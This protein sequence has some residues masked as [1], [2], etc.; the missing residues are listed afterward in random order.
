MRTNVAATIPFERTYEGGAAERSVPARELERTVLSCMLWE[1]NFYEKGSDTGKRI[2]SLCAKVPNDSI[3]ELAYRARHQMGLRHV[4]LWLL[5]QVARKGPKQMGLAGAIAKTIKRPDEMSELLALYWKDGRVPISAQ[6]KKGLARAFGRFSSYQLAKWDRDGRIKLRDVMFLS[7]PKPKDGEQAALYKQVAA[8]TLDVP[9]TWE[10][11]LSTGKNKR[12]SWE[13]LL[14]EKKIGIMALLK[15]LRNMQEA[16]VPTPLVA[17]ALRE[18]DKGFAFPYRFLTAARYAPWLA[19]ELSEAMLER[20][21]EMPR[22]RGETHVIVDVSGSMDQALSARGEATRLDA[23]ASIAICARELC[24][25]ARV[26]TFSQSVAEIGNVHGLPLAAAITNSQPHQGTY[27][28]QALGILRS[29]GWTPD[30]IIVVTDEQTHDGNAPCHARRSG[31]IV[32][33]APYKNGLESKQKGWTRVNGWSDRLL[34]WVAV[35]ENEDARLD[36]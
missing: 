32:N 2:A 11:A 29:K 23:A 27:L 17:G 31:Y 4:P 6:I 34:E 26:F 12:E 7:H 22:L 35:A 15:N 25:S 5:V 21:K 28:A 33:V 8:R 9:D 30:R 3:F 24:E 19:S 20:I 10:V 14:S 16:G 1:D 18:T 13:R 36:G